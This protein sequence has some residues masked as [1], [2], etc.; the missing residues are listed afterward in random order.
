MAADRDGDGRKLPWL[1]ADA[2]VGSH[3]EQ[4]D[5]GAAAADSSRDSSERPMYRAPREQ[6]SAR[7][8]TVSQESRFLLVHDV[9]IVAPLE[10]LIRMFALFGAIERYD[11]RHDVEAPRFSTVVGIR[12]ARVE[13][14]RHVQLCESGLRGAVVPR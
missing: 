3:D 4:C 5:G 12:Y 9:P 7:A 10:D 1:V 6:R 2:S 8:Y 13:D 11:V 14:A